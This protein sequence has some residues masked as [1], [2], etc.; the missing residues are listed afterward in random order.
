MVDNSEPNQS[1]SDEELDKYGY[2]ISSPRRKTT[3]L[4]LEGDPGTPKEL[5]ERSD[6]S[7]SHV[8]NILSDLS[9]E[10]IAVCVNP[11][12]KRG[13]VY[14]LTEIGSRIANKIS[15]D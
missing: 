8:S 7:L 9:E 2:V 11:E 10:G 12:R 15:E 3:V 6:I 13:R 5:G 1:L 4:A 14:R